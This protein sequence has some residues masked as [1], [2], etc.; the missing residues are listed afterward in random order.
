[1]FIVK[2]SS[3]PIFHIQK[4]INRL[5]EWLSSIFYANHVVVCETTAIR[6]FKHR[7]AMA[8][9][10]GAHNTCTHIVHP[11]FTYKHTHARTYTCVYGI[12]KNK[13]S[14]PTNHPTNQT[15]SIIVSTAIS[16]KFSISR[17]IYCVC[18][19]I[20]L[21]SIRGYSQAIIFANPTI[22]PPKRTK[23]HRSSARI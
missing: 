15:V 17:V 18:T 10:N 22:P 5:G 2:S 21:L 7:N 12:I 13:N 1:M 16:M 14:K 20:R 3:I 6:I 9:P 19:N 23:E 4:L 8:M 11:Q